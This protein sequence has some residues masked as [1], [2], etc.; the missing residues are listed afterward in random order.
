[1]TARERDVLLGLDHGEPIKV[2]AI[3][4]GISTT[5]VRGY[6]Q[7]IFSRFEMHSAIAALRA[8]RISGLGCSTA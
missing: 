1:L 7:S 8:A 4:L 3:E 2:I 5:T 6:V